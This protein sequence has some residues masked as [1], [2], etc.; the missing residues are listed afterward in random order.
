MGFI[1]YDKQIG[2]L[3]TIEEREDFLLWFA[4]H[5]CAPDD[6]RRDICFGELERISDRDTDLQKLI[7]RGE[8]FGVT[9]EE[10]AAAAVKFSPFLAQLLHI[11]SD[12][13][14]GEWRHAP[15]ST[16]ARFWH[17]YDPPTY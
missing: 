11:I 3:V 9:E 6:P 4:T 13:T 17:K 14:T 2:V 8:F 7:P 1:G 5:R 10:C 15:G 12:I 16:E